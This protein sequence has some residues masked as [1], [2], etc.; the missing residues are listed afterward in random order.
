MNIGVANVKGGATKTTTAVHLAGFFQ[1]KGKTALL[2]GDRSHNAEV[3]Q[4]RGPGFGFPVI[5]VRASLRIAKDF[6]HFITD[7][8]SDP[9]DDDLKYL[10]HNCD[11]LVIPT[12][13]H[14]L[15]TDG[16]KL[17]LT[18]LGRLGIKHYKVLL[19]ACPPENEPDARELREALEELGIPM[20]KNEVPRTK[21]FMK[22]ASDGVLVRDLKGS[23]AERGW[24]AYQNVGKE[25]LAYANGTRK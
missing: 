2:D 15:E 4:K 3:W 25:C 14:A 20:F 22:A 23:L 6:E 5:D 21:M 12:K 7:S 24:A 1:T 16:L 9:T 19:A 8:G 11:L 10:A 17:T 18:A 13:P